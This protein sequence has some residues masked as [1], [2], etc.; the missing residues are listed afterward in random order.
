MKKI[1]MVSLLIASV[2]ALANCSA[3]HSGSPGIT[4]AASTEAPSAQSLQSFQT[5]VYA[6]GQTQ[7]CVQCHS[8]AVN[9][10]WMNADLATAY[11]FARPLL[12]VN[13][14]TN[15]IFATYVANDHC[16]NPICANSANIPTMQDLLSQWATVELSQTGENYTSVA[17]GSAMP[18]PPYVT[19]TMPI[20]SGLPLIT[21]KTPDVIRFDLSALTPPVASL[22]GAI[23]ELSIDLYNTDSTTYKVFN[24]RLA[25]NTAPVTIS[26]IH[27]YVRTAGGTG[28][29]TE[30]VNQG[31][32]WTQLTLTSEAMPLPSPLP[33]GPM[34]LITPLVTTSLGI[35]VQSS[36]DVIT[37]G[38]GG[39]Q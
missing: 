13:D 5:T 25:G 16:N 2:L 39:I 23:L 28:L 15:S 24:P 14:P 10:Q 37:V 22:N 12:N 11:S 34:T 38:F 7:G 36:S 27:V 29:G 4:I 32:Q 18:D 6:F 26:G 21:A 30:D 3:Q 1:G 9:P 19:A 35:A 8:G 20:P 17:A 33:S 31:L